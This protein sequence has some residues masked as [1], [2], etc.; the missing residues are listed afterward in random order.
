MSGILLIALASRGFSRDLPKIDLRFAA[1]AALG[2]Y[3]QHLSFAQLDPYAARSSSSVGLRAVRRY[4]VIKGFLVLREHW[5]QRR[6]VR[7]C[8]APQ[9]RLFRSAGLCDGFFDDVCAPMIFFEAYGCC[10]QPVRQYRAPA[11]T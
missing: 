10:T 9:W 1:T 6:A 5:R 2:F 7:R 3:Q 8:Y 4:G 11:D